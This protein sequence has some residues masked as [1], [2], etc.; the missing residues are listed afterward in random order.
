MK[1]YYFIAK[2][3]WDEILS[4]RVNFSLWR[5]RTVVAV[6]ISYFLWSSVIPQDGS[7]FGYS[8]EMMI[9]YILIGPLLYS[10][11]FA[12]RTHEISDNINSGD[13]SLWLVKPFGY[14]KF[15]FAR[16]MGDKAMNL[17]FC[18]VEFSLL[19]LILRPEIYIQT[20]PL[21]LGLLIAAVILAVLL[22]FFIS[23]LISM[24]GFWSPEV[25][26]PRFI[27]YVLLSFFTG[28]VFP[29]DILAEPIFQF[30][31]MLPFAYLQYFPLKIYLGQVSW[32]EIFFGFSMLIAWIF[33][34]YGALRLAWNKGLRNYT[35][36]GR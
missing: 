7:L 4:Y 11:I 8:R 28:A 19:L 6:L 3:T 14:F 12:T 35:A 33:V 31:M 2:N 30:L 9:S 26:A 22:Q 10:I 25:W 32:N 16:D 20:N 1:K 21:Y 18:V 15:W 36:S 13:L 5:I 29:L 17:A 34:F 24:I 27:F 23:C